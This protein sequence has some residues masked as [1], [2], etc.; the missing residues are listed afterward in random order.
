MDVNECE[1]LPCLHGGS[2]INR[3]GGYQC[4]CPPGFT[5]ERCEVNIDEC[6]S[7]PCLHDGSCID[8]IASY[9]CHCKRGFAGTECEIDVNE[10][11]PDPCLHGRWLFLFNCYYL[12]DNVLNK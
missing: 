9:K 10:C 4:S 7:A 12:Q 5:G 2:C 8:D 11:L 6:L 3:L 1:T